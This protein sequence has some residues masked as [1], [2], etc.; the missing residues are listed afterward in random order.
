MRRRIM[1]DPFCAHLCFPKKM[2]GFAQVALARQYKQK[3]AGRVLWVNWSAPVMLMGFTYSLLR[4]TASPLRG[5]STPQGMAKFHQTERVALHSSLQYS[6][7]GRVC[8]VAH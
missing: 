7:A 8:Q 2:A 1:A 5:D 6:D 3:G 4:D